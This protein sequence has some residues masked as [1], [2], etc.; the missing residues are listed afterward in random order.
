MVHLRLVLED[1]SKTCM[2]SC[3]HSFTYAFVRAFTGYDSILGVWL[4][5]QPALLKL[6]QRVHTAR[7]AGRR[8][9]GCME[10]G[11]PAAV[12]PLP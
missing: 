5:W 11:H 10:E 7:R 9:P 12:Q 2:P 8:E 6:F 3:I 4:L 1:Q